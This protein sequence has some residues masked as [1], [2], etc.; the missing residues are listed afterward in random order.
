MKT[1]SEIGNRHNRP[2][3][4]QRRGKQDLVPAALRYVPHKKPTQIRVVFDSSAVYKGTSL[5][6]E[7]LSGPDVLNNLHGI[8]IRFR[9]ET[10][11]VTC[12]IE[13]M[14]HCFYVNQNHRNV[15]RFLWF[16]DN[17]PT[18]EIV[19]Y[20]MA[21]HL[22]GNTCSPAIATFGLRKTAEDGEEGF[23]KLAKEFV[24]NDFYV[25]D[26]LTSCSILQEV[27]ELVRNTQAMHDAAN[28]RLHKIVSNSVEVITALPKQDRVPKLRELHFNADSLPTQRSLGV[29]WNLEKDAFTF[30]V[31]L[32]N[33]SY[34]RRGML[35][36]VNSVY[37]TLGFLPPCILKGRILFRK[38]VAMG[39]QKCTK[40]SS[41]G[42][43]DPLSESITREW[44]CWRDSLINLENVFIP[45]CY[46]GKEFGQ[47]TRSE[48][49]AF[50]DASQEA[51]GTV[52]YL[53]QIN[54]IRLC[55]SKTWTKTAND[56]S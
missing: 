31:S 5:N 15:L 42:W 14:F 55:A 11:G 28:I 41:L 7:L 33:K 27:V 23:G 49:H 48:L 18:K 51:I 1:N 6:K 29:C 21:V 30:R 45:R 19:E 4:R 13:Q 9:Q 22:F 3:R 37:D 10:I 36:I 52:V 17:N 32:P 39:N 35:A 40:E 20:R 54:C 8:M 44:Q 53:K 56:Y 2:A 34:T 25:D 43:D 12:D 46:H 47:I 24:H 50:S 38:L 16:K 26:G